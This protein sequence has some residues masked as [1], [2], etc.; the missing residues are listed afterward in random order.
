[1]SGQPKKIQVEPVHCVYCTASKELKDNK[2]EYH[3]V[4]PE[5]KAHLPCVMKEEARKK[6]QER[7]SD[8]Y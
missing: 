8:Y 1:M 2:G 3:P 4:I 6:K 5:I 7:D